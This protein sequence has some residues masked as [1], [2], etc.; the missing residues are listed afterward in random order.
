MAGSPK[1]RLTRIATSAALT[2]IPANIYKLLLVGGS[3]DSTVKLYNADSAC[4]DP[5]IEAA[6]LAGT[7]EPVDLDSLGPV[8]FT[9]KGYVAIAGAGAV[10]YIWYG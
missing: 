6:A 10:A 7:T 8:S 1:H 9:D 3:G 5:M 2:V 4:G